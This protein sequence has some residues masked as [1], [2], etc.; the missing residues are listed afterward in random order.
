M[1]IKG[2]EDGVQ[3]AMCLP[4]NKRM[5]AS[6]HKVLPQGGGKKLEACWGSQ[7]ICIKTQ[8]EGISAVASTPSIID[9]RLRGV[10]GKR[11]KMGP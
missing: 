4:R 5:H 7:R 1:T 3:S 9:V 10:H 11:R 2:L 8:G 6:V